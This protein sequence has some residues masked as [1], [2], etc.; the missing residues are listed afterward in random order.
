MFSLKSPEGGF[1]LMELLVVI[2][3]LG[4]LAAIVVPSVLMFVGSGTE[5]SGMME[6][7]NMVIG[8]GVLE[9]LSASGTISGTALNTW[10]QDFTGDAIYI[11]D[12]GGKRANL[13]EFVQGDVTE[14]W[15]LIEPDG[16]IRGAYDPA[17][18]QLIQ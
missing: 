14:F 4:V 18:T 2:A 9:Y 8:V 3:I 1:T 10:T 6:F 5:E 13:Y 16:D 11:I 12:E 15:Y 17:G 7:Q